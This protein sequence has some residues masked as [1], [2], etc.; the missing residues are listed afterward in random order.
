MV[1]FPVK[2]MKQEREDRNKMKSTIMC[3]LDQVHFKILSKGTI[4]A[5]LFSNT[6]PMISFSNDYN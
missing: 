2:T 4:Y 6:H 1:S 5:Y 3:Y